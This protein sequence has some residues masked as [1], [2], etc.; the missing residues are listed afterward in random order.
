MIPTLEQLRRYNAYTYLSQVDKFLVGQGLLLHHNHSDAHRETS[1]LDWRGANHN[2]FLDQVL[3]NLT[4]AD[5]KLGDFEESAEGVRIALDKL[6]NLA[7][8][9]VDYADGV[10]KERFEIAEESLGYEVIPKQAAK[11]PEDVAEAEIIHA[12]L[13]S[14]VGEFV[15]YAQE[16]GAAFT[17]QAGELSVVNLPGGK[18]RALPPDLN[19]DKIRMQLAKRTGEGCAAGGIPTFIAGGPLAG[20]TGCATVAGISVLEYLTEILL[21]GKG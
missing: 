17:Q 3:H 15:A 1:L 16:V 6:N 18:G 4:G 10:N 2:A 7:K 19:P 8:A 11:H 5:V 14:L 20:A 9:V 13:L 12:K 21:T